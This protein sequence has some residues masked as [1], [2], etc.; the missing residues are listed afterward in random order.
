MVEPNMAASMS[1]NRRARSPRL[2]Q[3]HSIFNLHSKSTRLLFTTTL[4]RLDCPDRLDWPTTRPYTPPG[5]S[6]D[7][8]TIPTQYTADAYRLTSLTIR[9]TRVGPRQLI[10]YRW[11]TTVDSQLFNIVDPWRFNIGSLS[12]SIYTSTYHCRSTQRTWCIT[13]TKTLEAISHTMHINAVYVLIY[14]TC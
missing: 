2:R 4:T 5:L 9:T 8:Q 6:P 11:S 13:Y 10:Y 3:I 12:L 1:F 7:G 14:L